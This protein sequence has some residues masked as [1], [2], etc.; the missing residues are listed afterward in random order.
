MGSSN[1]MRATIFTGFNWDPALPPLLGDYSGFTALAANPAQLVEQLNLLLMS[2]Q[3]SAAMKN[4]MIAEIT[5][6]PSDP[7]ERVKEAA[8]SIMTAPEYVIQK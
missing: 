5:K 3:M 4:T 2:G 1:F 6:M 7:I 8:H